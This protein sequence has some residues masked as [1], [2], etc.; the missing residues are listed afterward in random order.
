MLP[1]ARVQPGDGL[2]LEIEGSQSMHVYVLSEDAKGDVFVLFPAPGLDATNPLGTHQTHRLPGTQGG[3]PVN[4]QVTSA[5]GK[6]SVIVVASRKPQTDLERDIAGFPLAS[7]ERPVVYG[8]VSSQ[9]LATLRG[10]GGYTAARPTGENGGGRLSTVLRN[11]PG[12][13]TSA[14]DPWIWQ[15]ELSNPEH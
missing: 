5:G 4:W 2:F 12:G 10:I 11:L 1:G 14:Q 9:T 13:V 7:A 3:S 8:E 15:I 6:E